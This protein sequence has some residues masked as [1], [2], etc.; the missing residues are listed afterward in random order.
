MGEAREATALVRLVVSL[1]AVATTLAAWL[2]MVADE[3]PSPSATALDVPSLEPLPTLE[4]VREVPRGQ[5]PVPLAT[6]RSSR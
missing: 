1:A 3:A 5:R 6:T 2:A 4:P